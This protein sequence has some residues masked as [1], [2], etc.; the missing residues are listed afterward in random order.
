MKKKNFLKKL[1]KYNFTQTKYVKMSLFHE[2]H[3]T[4]TSGSHFNNSIY[5]DKYILYF[6]QTVLL[7][8]MLVG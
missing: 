6:C 1:Q 4:C 5:F 8:Q 7:F 2:R 3:T